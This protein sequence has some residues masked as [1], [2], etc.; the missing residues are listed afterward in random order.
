LKSLIVD[1]INYLANEELKLVRKEHIPISDSE[2]LLSSMNIDSLEYMIMY[3]WLGDIFNIPNEIFEELEKE[4]DITLG[5]ITS[6]IIEHYD[7]DK[8]PTLQEA[9]DTYNGEETT[10]E[11]ISEGLSIDIIAE[12]I[13]LESISDELLGEEQCI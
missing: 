10:L 7:Q 12:E 5:Y 4:G 6:F 2:E 3:M 8:A 11:S 1:I 13:P 9:I